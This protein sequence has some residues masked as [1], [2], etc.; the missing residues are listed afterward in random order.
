MQG[1]KCRRNRIRTGRGADG[2]GQD[3]VDEQRAAGYQ[4]ERHTEIFLGDNVC[5]PA[6]RIGID[7]LP[8]RKD[9]NQQQPQDGKGNG[10]RVPEGGEADRHQYQ[11]N[12]LRAISHGGKGVRRQNGQ[13]FQLGQLFFCQFR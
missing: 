2:H 9:E 13:C 12:L 10:N 1:R 4:A 7:G 11:Q 6:G 3:V 8:V 5:S